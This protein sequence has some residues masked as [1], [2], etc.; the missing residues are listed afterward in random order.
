LQVAGAPGL[1]HH[2]PP[3]SRFRPTLPGPGRNQLKSRQNQAKI[4][5]KSSEIQDKSSRLSAISGNLTKL[6]LI[7][8]NCK[9]LQIIST[10]LT[11]YQKRPTSGPVG[12]W[13]DGICARLMALFAAQESRKRR[14]AENPM[15]PSTEEAQNRS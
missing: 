7:A 15:P 1:C 9:E 11:E 4:K 10:N 6:Q 5:G 3:A 13:A 12:R 8:R 2:R 14:G